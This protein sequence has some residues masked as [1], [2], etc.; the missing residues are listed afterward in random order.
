MAPVKTKCKHPGC[1]RVF[2]SKQNAATHYEKEHAKRKQCP[3][4]NKLVL[5]KRVEEHAKMHERGVVLSDAAHECSVCKSGFGSAR[6]LQSHMRQQHPI[7]GQYR[8]QSKARNAIVVYRKRFNP[9]RNRITSLD[10][11]F[12]TE[13]DAIYDIIRQELLLKKTVRYSIIPVGLFERIS[14]PGEKDARGKRKE[15]LLSTAELYLRTK[16]YTTDLGEHESVRRFRRAYQQNASM[17]ASRLEDMEVSDGSG[18]NLQHISQM[19]LEIGKTHYLKG[20]MHPRGFILDEAEAASDCS[21]DEEEEEGG[22]G[23]TADFQFIDDDETRVGYHS[24]NDDDEI[25]GHAAL[26]QRQ[27]RE[28]DEEIITLLRSRVAGGRRE[29]RI[30][31]QWERRQLCVSSSSEEEQEQENNPPIPTDAMEDCIAEYGSP[32]SNTMSS[33]SDN[34]S[35]RANN[36]DNDDNNSSSSSEEE[37]GNPKERK[38]HYNSLLTKEPRDGALTREQLSLLLA[39]YNTAMLSDLSGYRHEKEEIEKMRG[40]CLY[41]VLALSYFLRRDSC[42]NPSD[43]MMRK[44]ALEAQQFVFDCFP[45]EMIFRNADVRQLEKLESWLRRERESIFGD[46][47]INLLGYEKKGAVS[48]ASWGIVYPL[49]ISPYNDGSGK[50]AVNIQHLTFRVRERVEGGEEEQTRCGH[51]VYI[52][53]FDGYMRRRKKSNNMLSAIRPACIRCMQYFGSKKTLEQHVRYCQM[54][55][56]PVRT[57]FPCKGEK[58]F[59]RDHARKCPVAVFGVGDFECVLLPVKEEVLARDEDGSEREQEEGQGEGWECIEEEEEEEAVGRKTARTVKERVHKPVAFCLLFLRVDL[60][61]DCQHSVLYEATRASDNEEELMTMYF[62]CLEEA[63]E[64][65]ARY[66][67]KYTGVRRVLS[68]EEKITCA[69]VDLCWICEQPMPKTNYWVPPGKKKTAHDKKMMMENRVIDHCH[70]T[71]MLLGVCHFR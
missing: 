30:R 62:E 5:E 18:W 4:C 28:E 22:G 70:A 49:R 33:E 32:E 52:R 34:N 13:R 15:L 17:C 38:F 12:V 19:I 71:N 43:L 66:E 48:V 69:S 6:A 63:S 53:N 24:N 50:G 7:P 56:D 65:I 11:L 31:R 39:P 26:L 35:E 16:S 67:R 42:P 8:V 21:D 23:G 68:P 36:S 37:Y 27:N 29:E 59:F 20:G 51:F 55:V 47:A 44:Y 1:A 60:R 2:A 57:V 9:R 41:D 25:V 45:E 10:Y 14:Q 61:E 3:V 54:F 64:V 58:L 40:L 46:L